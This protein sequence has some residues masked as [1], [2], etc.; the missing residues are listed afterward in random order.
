MKGRHSGRAMCQ[1]QSAD[2]TGISADMFVACHDIDTIEE[3][4]SSDDWDVTYPQLQTG[5]FR[6]RYAAWT[7][8]EVALT[9]ESYDHK[10][11]VTGAAPPGGP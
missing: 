11:S 9:H 1:G 6:G 3:L 10:V 8:S 2:E 5:R 7:L 4:A